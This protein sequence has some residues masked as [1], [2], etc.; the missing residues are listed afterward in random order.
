LEKSLNDISSGILS[1]LA[2]G[3]HAIKNK[4]RVGAANRQKANSFRLPSYCFEPTKV[5]LGDHLREVKKDAPK[6]VME[7]NVLGRP[8]R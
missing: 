4:L 3:D 2:V 7:A 8:Q 6:M 5:E 1:K